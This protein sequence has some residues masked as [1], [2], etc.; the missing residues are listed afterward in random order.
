MNAFSFKTN[1]IINLWYK[2]LKDASFYNI[3]FN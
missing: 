3:Y 1:Y 2:I